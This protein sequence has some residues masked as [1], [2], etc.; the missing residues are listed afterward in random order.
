MMRAIIA[1]ASLSLVART[2]TAQAKMPAQTHAQSAKSAQSAKPAATV[3]RPGAKLAVPAADTSGPPPTIMREL[4]VYAADGRRDPF[5]SL[6]TTGELRPTISDLRVTGIIVDQSP[7]RRS[8]ATLRDL[9][10]NAQYRIVLGSKLG[11]MTVTAI[12]PKVIL[13]TID[14]FGTTRQ[15]SLVMGDTTKVRG[16]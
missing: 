15:D 16:K 2:A 3:E 13:F 12:R 14:E 1:A 6:L 5:V 10:T 7:A 9:V 8:V 11:R 4:Y